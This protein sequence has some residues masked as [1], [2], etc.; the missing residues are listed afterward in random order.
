L[1]RPLEGQLSFS[2]T[3]TWR[4]GL[5]VIPDTPLFSD[6]VLDKM[7]FCPI[8]QYSYPHPAPIKGRLAI[9]IA[10]RSGEAVAATMPGLGYVRESS[11]SHG[12]QG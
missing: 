5:K 1:A 8:R 7:D 11:G 6:F 12:E 2:G 9:V 3:I 4:I 10:A